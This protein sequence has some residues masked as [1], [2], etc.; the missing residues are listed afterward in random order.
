MCENPGFLFCFVSK[1]DKH[2]GVSLCCMACVFKRTKCGL[3]IIFIIGWID[4]LGLI[5]WTP[6]LS[7][8]SRLA[9]LSR[10]PELTWCHS[11]SYPRNFAAFEGSSHLLRFYPFSSICNDLGR[12]NQESAK[13][14]III[15]R[16]FEINKATKLIYIF[17]PRSNFH[18]FC[19]RAFTEWAWP[20]R[21]CLFFTGLTFTHYE[22][23]YNGWSSTVLYPFQA[24]ATGIAN[25]CCSSNTPVTHQVTPVILPEF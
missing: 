23:Q 13:F 10:R 15:Q 18:Q 16:N 20:A 22:F 21:V 9:S 19:F 11:S 17:I 12:R 4:G 2:K 14:K 7:E 5:L 1:L 6:R 25:P 3:K 24:R 8:W